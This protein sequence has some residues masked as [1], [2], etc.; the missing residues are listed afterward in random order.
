MAFFGLFGSKTGPAVKSKA[1]VVV[2]WDFARRRGVSFEFVKSLKN[3]EIWMIYQ[4]VSQDERWKALA[5]TYR[6]QPLQVPTGER[7]L[8]IYLSAKLAF[9]L[10]SPSHPYAEVIL[11]GSRSM[12]Q[13]LADFLKAAGIPTS[14]VK[15]GDTD[16]DKGSN[17]NARPERG[18][19]NERNDR[20][21]R[22]ERGERKESGERT[23]RNPRNER[24][25]QGERKE[26]NGERTGDRNNPRSNERREKTN[27]RPNELAPRTEESVRTDTGPRTESW[28]EDK[29]R[30]YAE[31][32]AEFFGRKYTLGET[33][34][35]SYF[36]MAIKQAT[37][38]NSYD[39]F[40]TKNASQFLAFLVQSGCLEEGEDQM[41][42]LERMPTAEELFEL[43]R[44]TT[45]RGP[46]NPGVTRAGIIHPEGFSENDSDDYSDTDVD[47][48]EDSDSDTETAANTTE[49]DEDD[50]Y[51]NPPVAKPVAD[52]TLSANIPDIDDE[53]FDVT[54][55][56]LPPAKP[57]KKDKPLTADAEAA[58]PVWDELT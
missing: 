8:S 16:N 50:A 43:M 25:P 55:Q 1:L 20:N 4:T 58:E 39:V 11:V 45:Q 6:V 29:L 30:L 3:P 37:G 40:R 33:Y 5:S 51:Y 38:R 24:G 21:P 52:S 12:Y 28:P 44:K 47:N 23:E 49:V 27:G 7:N 32:M 17:R 2:D 57:L 19:R 42:R 36:G 15:L 22:N 34:K 48:D 26:R 41:C 14:L 9:T 13:G 18:E 46:R 35:K 10:G 56:L 53:D 31:K 54:A